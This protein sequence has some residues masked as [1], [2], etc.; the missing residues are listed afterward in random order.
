MTNL[1]EVSGQ[2]KALKW[3]SISAN[4][5]GK[6]TSVPYR[7][8]DK[9]SAGSVVVVQDTADLN[10]MVR[11][12][13]AG[14]LQA[15]ARLSQAVTSAGV[16]STQT[17]A[18][19]AQAKAA[20]ESAKAGLQLVKK[21]ARSQELKSAENAVASAE[22]NAK[23]AEITL[24][25]TRDLYSQGAQSRQQ[26][27]LVQMQYDIA[28]AQLDTAKQQLSIVKAGARDEEIVS[29]QKQ[30]DQADE[31]YKS[32]ISTRANKSLRQ[33][34]IKTAKAGV[35][36]AEAQLAYARQQLSEAYIRTQVGGVISRRNVEPGQT[37][38]TG[39]ILLEIVALDSIYFEATVSEM[40]IDKIKMNQ[41]VAVTVDALPSRKF[42]GT[43]Q[44]ILPV[45]DSGSR[46]FT[47]RIKL[48]NRNGE[49]KPGMFARGGIEIGR[50]ANVV[51][52]PKD[53]IIS[54]KNGHAVFIVKGET[55]KQKAV[56][57]GFET[58]EEAEVL[59]GVSASDKLVVLGQ[60]K[61]SD[62]V[63]VNAVN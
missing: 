62:G 32:A 30:V 44:K 20:L 24:K 37:V 49:L 51:I 36:Q 5:S 26:M 8:G 60:D 54:S 10:S 11:Q 17:E 63:K 56:K 4:S 53:A 45:A 61:L 47:L 23:N 48:D 22:A 13:E 29:A 28:E 1:I 59:S 33:E 6:V 34:D 40:D 46:Q 31:A 3:T 35:V 14:V 9:V 27:D 25:R 43:V 21:G 18:G 2:I 16:S 38:G 57:L 19:I 42:I 12:A 39:T 50:H 15:K 52:I 55:A 41:T 7:E 58:R